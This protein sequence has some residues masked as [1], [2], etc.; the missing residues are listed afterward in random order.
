MKKKSSILFINGS[1]RLGG[2]RRSLV[3]LL[4]NID[5][6]KYEVDL[7]L[8]Y[9]GGELIDKLPKEV[10][11]A[12]GNRWLKLIGM[13]AREVW[14]S[15]NI[16]DIILRGIIGAMSHIMNNRHVFNLVFLTHKLDKA[17]DFGFAYSHNNGCRGLYG[18]C[19]QYLIRN[20]KANHKA[21]WIHTDYRMLK[22]DFKWEQELFSKLDGIVNISNSNQETFLSKM[23]QYSSKCF[24]VYNTICAN[25]IKVLS[26]EKI[27][28]LRGKGCKYTGV[29]VARLDDNKAVHRVIGAIA[30]L[31]REGYRLGWIVVGDG[32]NREALEGQVLRENLTDQI[33][34]VGTQKNPYPYIAQAD[35]LCISSVFEGMPMVLEEAL[36]LGKP[37]IAAEY[38]AVRE[39]VIEGV[40]G[41]IAANSDDGVYEGLKKWIE[42]PLTAAN[43]TLNAQTTEDL[44]ADGMKT[45]EEMIRSL[46]VNY[47][48][49]L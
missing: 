9:R 40:N 21:G 29:S 20:V 32:P 6:T 14:K 44:S 25:E 4:N 13:S 3:N 7:L 37:I 5:Y 1:L 36:C 38:A 15:K 46:S 18:G 48:Q 33:T 27:P 35:F 42:N 34:F 47:S 26:K 8:F 17:Y 19:Y 39:R 23:P 2:V 43:C 12:E 49:S 31:K 28:Y 11:L 10:R 16:L 41:L 22:N 45:F 30:Q 24:V